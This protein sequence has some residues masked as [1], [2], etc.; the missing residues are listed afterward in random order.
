MAHV[1]TYLGCPQKLGGEAGV[2]WAGESCHT[3]QALSGSLPS[4]VRPGFRRY[5]TGC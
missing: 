5:S 1:C 4:G 2:R 3:V